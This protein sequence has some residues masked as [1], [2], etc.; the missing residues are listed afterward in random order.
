M[1]RS[2]PH[3][4]TPPESKNHLIDNFKKMHATNKWGLIER[5]AIE[6]IILVYSKIISSIQNL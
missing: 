5:S 2:I 6:D 3:K 4:Q 1:E